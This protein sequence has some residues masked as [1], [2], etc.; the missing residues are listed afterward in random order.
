MSIALNFD[1]ATEK[2]F[3]VTDK[4]LIDKWNASHYDIMIDAMTEEDQTF[5]K[6]MLI[7]CKFQFYYDVKKS[8]FI[9]IQKNEKT[10][11]L[12][13]FWKVD[14][15][16]D[17]SADN[18]DTSNLEYKDNMIIDK[19]IGRRFDVNLWELPDNIRPI[20]LDNLIQGKYKYDISYNS[21]IYHSH[22]Y[23]E[24]P[25]KYELFQIKFYEAFPEITQID[26][27]KPDIT[28]E[29]LKTLVKSLRYYIEALEY[30]EYRS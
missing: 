21:D 8:I 20:I 2:Q 11:I 12:L 10:R 30:G 27:N 16:I 4:L 14:K 28:I 17:V 7:E 13:Q 1:E 18:F 5:I 9:I 22:I 24:I 6:N 15:K 19:L 23:L 25:T 26:E 3:K 29:E